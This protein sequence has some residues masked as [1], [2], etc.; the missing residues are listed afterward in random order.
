MYCIQADGLDADAHLVRTQRCGFVFLF[1]FLFLFIFFMELQDLGATE[2]VEA[3]DACHGV[4]AATS[5]T[6]LT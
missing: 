5:I 4:Q 3:D 1:L 2:R 6:T